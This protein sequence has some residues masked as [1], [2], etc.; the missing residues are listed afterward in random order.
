M[1][2]FSALASSHPSKGVI[3]RRIS[4]AFLLLFSGLK[5]QLQ[6][7]SRLERIDEPA[8]FVMRACY[9]SCSC[10]RSIKAVN[11][12]GSQMRQKMHII[13]KSMHDNVRKASILSVQHRGGFMT[14]TVCRSVRGRTVTVVCLLFIR[15]HA[16]A[17]YSCLDYRHIYHLSQIAEGGTLPY[18]TRGV[19]ICVHT[20]GSTRQGH[21]AKS[22]L[23]QLCQ[24][25]TAA[26][27]HRMFMS[28]FNHHRH[29][30]TDFF[31]VFFFFIFFILFCIVSIN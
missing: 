18:S 7:S 13:L 6:S 27:K 24:F 9:R 25:V 3:R 12:A 10:C 21:E 17:L 30:R 31:S 5:R 16:R 14:T 2:H 4:F 15:G 20:S 26:G 29:H 22:I 1:F 28:S 8:A 11:F 19:H 23:C